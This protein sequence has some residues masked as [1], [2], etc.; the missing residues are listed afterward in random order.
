MR[1]VPRRNAAARTRAAERRPKAK[2]SGGA[3][4][5][6][7]AARRSQ[8]GA[9]SRSGRRRQTRGRFASSSPRRT[10]SWYAN[11]IPASS[12]STN[13][14]IR[15]SG[16]PS[17]GGSSARAGRPAVASAAATRSR[18][19]CRVM[20]VIAPRR[21]A[22]RNAHAG[23]E[24]SSGRI[25]AMKVA[26]I[27]VGSNSL[28]MVVVEAREGRDLRVLDREK[29]M[30]RLGDGAFRDGRLAASAQ[31]R[32]LSTIER[33]LRIARRHGV[34]AVVCA[35]TSAVREAE[36]GR[37]FLALLRRHTGLHVEL[38]APLEEARL[39]YLA[40][41]QAMDLGRRPVL[42]LDLGG[43]S[44]EVIVGDAATLRHA[45][46]LPLGVLR[47]AA[48]FGGKGGALSRK[49]RRLLREHV[50]ETLAEPLRRARG[51]GV[52]RAIGTAGTVN[53]I[54]RILGDGDDPDDRLPARIRRE[55]VHDLAE[56]LLASGPA[57]R[58]RVAGMD[59]DRSDT[60][61]FGA[62]VV[63]ETL[64]GL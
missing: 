63:D 62:V 25:G 15:Q 40:V 24:V 10:P 37:A 31:A 38:L 3:S 14:G 8:P 58:R 16:D 35:A 4:A 49:R 46:S 17:R 39:I 60:V 26:A 56:S 59:P 43:G 21:S 44:A 55:D 48:K 29:D 12:S 27:D 61:G 1:S 32:A 53:A 18:T 20:A 30:V 47:L 41:R 34:D 64:R 57:K 2:T 51:A 5:E 23:T 19:A 36:N 50:R 7:L 6:T 45:H 22:G 52:R 9:S 13:A 33:F 42:V 28:H 11:I 54:A